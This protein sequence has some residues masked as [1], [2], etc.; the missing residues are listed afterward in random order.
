MFSR[1]DQTWDTSNTTLK[2]CALSDSRQPIR[3]EVF[4]PPIASAP[5]AVW[6]ATF[7]WLT[8]DPSSSSFSLNYS[9]PANFF[10]GCHFIEM[11]ALYIGLIYFGRT[12]AFFPNMLLAWVRMESV[13]PKLIFS[14]QIWRHPSGT[15]ESCWYFLLDLLSI[16]PIS[17]P[18]KNYLA[19]DN[20]CPWTISYCFLLR[21]S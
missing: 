6:V 5:L 11:L 19:G 14:V 13:F 15:F 18:K 21:L 7:R 9:L 17:S 4:R 8:I 1:N 3:F 10:V 2:E 16:L 20:N 12:V